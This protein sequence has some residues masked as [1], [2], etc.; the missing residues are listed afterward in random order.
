MKTNS[1]RSNIFLTDIS[2]KQ[3]FILS[4]SL[5][6]CQLFPRGKSLELKE[7]AKINQIPSP[8]LV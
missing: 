6:S 4:P 5:I 8:L 1:N 7:V 3:V 2:K